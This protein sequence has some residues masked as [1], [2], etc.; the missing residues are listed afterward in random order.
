MPIYFFQADVTF[1]C[2]SIT[3]SVFVELWLS[4][5]DLAEHISNFLIE[6]ILNWGIVKINSLVFE[7]LFESTIEVLLI[8]HLIQNP[9]ISSNVCQRLPESEH[10][11]LK[12]DENPC[13]NSWHRVIAELWKIEK[14]G[15]TC[16]VT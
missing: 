3:V 9:N 15:T 14:C 2:C 7:I 6:S 8:G 13:A 11:W 16:W 5:I 1:Y 4:F 12:F 10:R